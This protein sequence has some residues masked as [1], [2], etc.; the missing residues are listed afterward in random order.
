MRNPTIGSNSIRFRSEAALVSD[1]VGKLVASFGEGVGIESEFDCGHGIAD[2]VAYRCT[3]GESQIQRIQSLSPRWAAA[4]HALPYRR[5][6]TEDWFA[7]HNLVSVR[8]TRLALREYE[9]AGYCKRLCKRGSWIKCYQP[10]PVVSEIH[11]IEAKLKDWQRALSQAARYR[12]FAHQA[13]VLLDDA[14][15][16]PALARGEL[17]SK[18]NVGL[19]SLCP[20][21][22]FHIYHKPQPQ[23]PSNPWRYWFANVLI[24]RK[25]FKGS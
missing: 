2:L 24:A 25:L 16:R 7:A 15:I 14:S 8:R 12:A 6:F 13:W 20:E 21:G 1:A 23:M 19:V 18:L 4:L 3:R 5:A 11:A 17:F 10:K 22:N 9:L